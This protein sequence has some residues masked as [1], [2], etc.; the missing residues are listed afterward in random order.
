MAM[1][2]LPSQKG[3]GRRTPMADINVTPLVDVMLVLLVIFMVT[4]PLLVSG[5]PVDLPDSRAKG[6]DQG[7]TPVQITVNKDNKIFIDDVEVTMANLPSKLGEIAATGQA[8]GLDEKGPLL[9]LR[10]DGGLSHEAVMRVM[11]E[12]NNAGLKRIAFITTQT[13]GE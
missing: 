4:A 11:G 2:Q 7:D 13:G 10:A 6:L 12:I 3:R 9:Y 5:V 1:S 8:Q